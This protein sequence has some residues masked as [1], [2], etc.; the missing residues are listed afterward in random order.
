MLSETQSN[1]VGSDATGTSAYNSI[2]VLGQG[3][4]AQCGNG[5]STAC[6]PTFPLNVTSIPTK[7]TYS[8]VQQWS[9][10]VQR[11]VRK[12]MVGQLAYVG[13]KGTHL[14]AVRDLNQRRAADFNPF[15][16]GQ[17]ITASVCESGARTTNGIPTG[18][19]SVGG[20]NTPNQA[21]TVPNSAVITPTDPGYLNMFIACSGNPGFASYQDPSHPIKLGISADALRPYPGFS[22]IISVENVADSEYNALQATLRETTGPLT[23]GIAYTWSHSLDD[24]SDRSSANFADSLNIHSNRASSDFDQ[25]HLLNVNYIYDLPLLHLLGGF[26]H[27]MGTGSD[28][29]DESSTPGPDKVIVATRS[30]PENSSWR[31]ATQR[32]HD[33]SNRLAIQRHQWRWV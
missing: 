10:S 9:L 17:P 26:S 16:P 19:F 21:T 20:L 3:A 33:L 31:M 2:G 8:Y 24:S 32:H 25:R 29:S 1:I 23:I 28:P 12:G 14:S 27:L 5:A 13:T 30:R 18:G 22:N 6:G 4:L 7:A 15:A 11:E